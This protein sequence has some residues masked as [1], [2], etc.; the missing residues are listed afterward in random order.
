MD[1]EKA[2]VLIVEE[3]V[4]ADL[5]ARALCRVGCET[6]TMHTLEAVLLALE[7]RGADVVLCG[8]SFNGTDGIDLLRKVR[9]RRPDVPV[10]MLTG[11]TGVK[12]AVAA[13]RQGAFDCVSKPFEDD[14]LLSSINRALEMNNL[15]REN[16][17]LRQQLDVAATAAGFVG[18]SQSIRNLVALI[19][20][21]APSRSTVLIEG[22]SGTGKE[23]I[24]RM[25]HY[26]SNRAEGPFIAVNCKA[27]AEGIVESELFGHERGSFTGAIS[28]RA[29]C[30]E[31]ASGGTLF[32]DEIGEAGGDFQAKLL[33]V[34]EDGEV[35]RV[36][37]SKPRR[38]DV[39]IVAATNRVLRAEVAADRFRAD[40][41][42]R[43][44]VIPVRIPPLRERIA[45]ILPLARHFLAFHSAQAGRQISMSPAAEEALINY[46][47]PGNVRE[48]ENAIERAVVLSGIDVLTPEYFAFEAFGRESF[49][50]GPAETDANHGLVRTEHQSLQACLDRAASDRIREALEATNGNRGEAAAILG[51]DRTTL[52]RLMKRL[53]IGG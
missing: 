20:R 30:F 28:A 50:D 46:P 5:A 9:T 34:L 3:G 38:I 14:E 49:S 24:A 33:R 32:L 11:D 51:I 4:T 31:R 19:R 39:R 35:L 15:R 16:H 45:D 52:Y 26:W 25:L 40:L 17:R 13:M 2:R 12:G 22:E 27:F 23:L 42:F 7:Q 53:N 43:L 47:W 6:E 36:G 48:L 41:Y 18:E 29:G 21:V 1:S 8:S 37:G 10:V 44:N